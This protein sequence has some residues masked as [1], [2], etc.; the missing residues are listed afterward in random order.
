MTALELLPL[1]DW[2]LA[3][4]YSAWSEEWWAAG[5]MSDAEGQFVQAVLDG[6]HQGAPADYEREGVAKIRA[7]LEE[8]Q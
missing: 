4:L 8:A 6:W 2:I 5:W 3:T 7:L 1:P